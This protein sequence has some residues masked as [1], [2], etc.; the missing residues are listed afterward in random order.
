MDNVI[1]FYLFFGCL[2]LMMSRE[3][4]AMTN[5]YNAYYGKE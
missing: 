3:A 1:L 2:S 5:A 4:K